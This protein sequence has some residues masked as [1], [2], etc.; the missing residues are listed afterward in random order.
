MVLESSL[1]HCNALGGEFSSGD[2]LMPHDLVEV[3]LT[4]VWA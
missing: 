4:D 3:S 1:V 2:F